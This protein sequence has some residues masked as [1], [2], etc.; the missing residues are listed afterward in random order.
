MFILKIV[1]KKRISKKNLI[2]QKNPKIWLKSQF[3][4]I[5]SSKYA[6]IN[7]VGNMHDLFNLKEIVL[8]MLFGMYHENKDA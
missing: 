8:I 4:I 1:L 5:A 7:V 2:F 6:K 3:S